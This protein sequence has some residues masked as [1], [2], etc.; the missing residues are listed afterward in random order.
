MATVRRLI[1]VRKG[2]RKRCHYRE[3]VSATGLRAVGI[4]GGRA[5]NEA[6]VRTVG[7]GTFGS[8]EIDCEPTELRYGDGSAE[9]SARFAS[10]NSYKPVLARLIQRPLSYPLGFSYDSASPARGSS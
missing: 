8:D 1:S 5:G 7:C 6:C 9:W 3:P 2:I 4:V 10:D